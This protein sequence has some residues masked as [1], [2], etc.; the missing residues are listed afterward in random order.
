[1]SVVLVVEWNKAV[2][3]VSHSL[4]G[5]EL[6]YPLIEKFAYSLVLAN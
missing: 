6:N 4:E 2:Y 3:D 1:V 5:A